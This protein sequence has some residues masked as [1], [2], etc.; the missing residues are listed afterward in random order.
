ML[1][2]FKEVRDQS[3][4]CSFFSSQLCFSGLIFKKILWLICFIVV[5]SILFSFDGLLVP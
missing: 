3:M 1:T 2:L 4:I 5:L